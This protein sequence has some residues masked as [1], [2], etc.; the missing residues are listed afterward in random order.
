[1]C[2]CV[3]IKVMRQIRILLLC[4]L[5]FNC[6]QQILT[7]GHCQEKVFAENKKK[8]E[9]FERFI[10]LFVCIFFYQSSLYVI[11]KVT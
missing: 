3:C 4:Y 9:R 11:R 1:M 7:L 8:F 6:S 2:V 5:F 10:F